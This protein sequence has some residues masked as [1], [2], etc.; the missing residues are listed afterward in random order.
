MQIPVIFLIFNRP[1]TTEQV[2]ETIRQAQP[3][4]LLVVADGS[5]PSKP[6]EAEACRLTREI[7]QRVDWPC[8]VLT[9]FS[10]ENLGCKHRVASGL[11]WAFSLVEEAIILEDDCLPAPSF[12]SFC[13]TLLNQYRH[14]DRVMMIAGTNTEVNL[15]SYPYSYYFSRHTPFWGWA[16]WRR[17]WEHFDITMQSWPEY[18]QL[19]LIYS[20]CE[21]EFEKRFWVKHFDDV[22]AGVLDSWGYIWTYTCWFQNG[23]TIIPNSNLI[24]NIGYGTNATHTLQMDSLANLPTQDMWDLKHPPFLSDYRQIDRL[25]FDRH[26][27]GESIRRNWMIWK[28]ATAELLRLSQRNLQRRL[29]LK[30][31]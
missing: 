11:N 22:Y 10:D 29:K 23:L 30:S 7:I 17:A 2:F 25:F 15:P 13:E 5:R 4:Q 31:S 3:S 28:Q 24:S 8:D 14:D 16:T 20:Y 9:N 18:K 19:D 26:R 27:G 6:Q 1:D 12:F 21:D